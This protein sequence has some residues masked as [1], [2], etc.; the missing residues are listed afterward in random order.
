[1]TVRVPVTAELL[2]WAC[3]RGGLDDAART[4]R[5]PRYEAWEAGT[6]QPTLRQLEDFAR[7]THAPFGYFFGSDLR[8]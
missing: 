8:V 5:F 7:A 6:A 1:M 4:R 2:R 3:E